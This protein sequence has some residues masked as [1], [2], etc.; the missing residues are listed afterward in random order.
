[1]AD[2]AVTGLRGR[3]RFVDLSGT[4]ITRRQWGETDRVVV[5]IV[6]NGERND[7]SRD[8]DER[9]QP[10]TEL[11]ISREVRVHADR[12][13][14]RRHPSVKDRPRRVAQSAGTHSGWSAAVPTPPRQLSLR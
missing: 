3:A 5:R 2:E 9:R 14:L 1:M 11:T 8:K 12:G 7:P 13:Y 6:R 4:G 10:S